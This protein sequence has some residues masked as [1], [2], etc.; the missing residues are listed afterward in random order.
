MIIHSGYK[1]EGE[2][3][4]EIQS[5]A[6][7]VWD[8]SQSVDLWNQLMLWGLALAAIAAVFVVLATRIVVNRTGQLSETQEL[9]S[10]A[11][12]RQLQFDLKG[13]DI[14]I[15]NLKLRSDTAEAGISSAQADAAR[16]NFLAEQ[17][18]LARVEL[19]KLV[20]W[21]TI[22]PEQQKK[23]AARLK[24]FP[25]VRIAFTV[26]AGDPEGFAF[27][28]QIAEVAVEAGWNIVAFAPVTNLGSFRTGVSITTTGDRNTL[29]ASD[30]LTAE[31]NLLNFD[32][33][34]SPEIDPRSTDPLEHDH[35]RMKRSLR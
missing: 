3:V 23:I 4:S 7:R 22:T 19:Q 10:A 25:K 27:A 5:L 20:E 24:R 32:A 18:K 14:E 2:N 15:G 9:L 29:D 16:A 21:R 35:F 30:A 6:F 34:R 26:N 13:K 8:L 12:D 11:E 28:T 17:E 31:L 1:C 33:T